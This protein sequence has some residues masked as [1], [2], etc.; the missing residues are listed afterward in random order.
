MIGYPCGG[1]GFESRWVTIT[2]LNKHSKRYPGIM[3]LYGIIANSGI[4]KDLADKK[5]KK[6]SKL[7]CI[8]HYI[9]RECSR[10]MVDEP[11]P[12]LWGGHQNCVLLGLLPLRV[13]WPPTGVVQC[14]WISSLA[15]AERERDEGRRVGGREKDR[16]ERGEIKRGR[17]ETG[18]GRKRQEDK[19]EGE[20]EREV[21]SERWTDGE[22]EC[23][24]LQRDEW[25]HII[26]HAEDVLQC[27]IH[28][29]VQLWN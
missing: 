12:S 24:F 25:V 2:I 26:M 6:F 29:C 16:G 20:R 18:R 19:E 22:K 5:K 23:R 4:Q 21:E 15:L 10:T 1:L 8:I 13:G 9:L 28:C 14:C 3:C 17:R 7:H 11:T 27:V